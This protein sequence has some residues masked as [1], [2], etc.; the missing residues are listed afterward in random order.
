MPIPQPKVDDTRNSYMA[1]CM[2]DDAMINEYPEEAQR[3]AVCLTEW[4]GRAN[5]SNFIKT[6]ELRNV[7]ILRAGK[8]NGHDVKPEHLDEMIKN[9]QAGVIEPYLNL[10]H[11]DKYT[12][13]VK[14]ALKVVAL[15]FVSQLRREGDRLIADFKQVPAK[16]AD[17]IKSGLLKKRSVEFYPRG[18]TTNGM[19]FNNVLKAVSFFGADVPAVN[20]LSDEFDVLLKSEAFQA[21]PSTADIVTLTNLEKE[22]YKMDEITLKKSEYETLV[23]LKSDAIKFRAD[24]ERAEIELATLKKTNSELNDHIKA[25]NAAV[26]EAIELKKSIEAEKA[27]AVKAEAEKFI[28]AAIE[29]GKILPKNKDYFVSEFIE[30]SVKPEKL[31]IFKEDIEGRDRVINL[32]EVGGVGGSSADNRDIS[33]LSNDEINDLIEAKMKRDNITFDAAAKQL[34]INV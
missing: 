18:Y 9:Y 20:G 5:Q 34:G 3:A 31:A 24:Y 16:I 23:Q 2:S 21:T 4:K 10:D 19:T 6:A 33:K 15:G 25:A 8:W 29:A 26:A 17:Y 32:G 22:N 1:R 28:T 13:R 12:D 11:D 7:E 30:K 14:Q 27:A